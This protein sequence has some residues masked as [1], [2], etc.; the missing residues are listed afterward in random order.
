MEM[1][2]FQRSNAIDIM[3]AARTCNLSALPNGANFESKNKIR[4]EQ[5][6]FT[7]EYQM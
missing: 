3:M 6:V 5:T 2:T 4:A 7:L 1:N